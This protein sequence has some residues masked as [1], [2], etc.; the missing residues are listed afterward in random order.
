MLPLACKDLR[1]TGTAAQ[2]ADYYTTAVSEASPGVG[3]DSVGVN[4]SG[5][6]LRRLRQ[7][8]GLRQQRL[9]LAPPDEPSLEPEH[10]NRP[11]RGRWDPEAPQRLHLV[12]QKG[13]HRS[14]GREVTTSLRG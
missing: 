13:Q 11:R 9:V 5:C 4:R 10:P 6:Q 14:A 3:T 2:E 7:G 8:A 12:H 1:A